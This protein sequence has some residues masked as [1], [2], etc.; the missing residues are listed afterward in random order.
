MK[1]T[2]T[3]ILSL[4]I[5][6]FSFGQLDLDYQ[7]PHEEILT[8]ADAKMPPVMSI[9]DDG[10]KAILIYRDQYKSIVELAEKEMRLAGLRINPVTNISSRTTFY[11]KIALF[12]PK[13]KEQIEV[14]G[15]PE[16]PRLSNLSWSPKQ[17]YIT[18]L[19]TTLT[20]NELWVID[21]KKKK[22]I[23]LTEGKINA[24]M[25]SAYTWLPNESGLIVKFLPQEKKELIDV[26][27]KVPTGP[28]VSVNEAG[29]EA[30]NRTYQDLLQNKDDEYNFEVLATS[31][32][33]YVNLKGKVKN[34]MDQ[35]MFRSVS[36]SPDG[37]YVLLS[38]VKKPFS[39]IVTYGRFPTD[40]M[41]V[42]QDA[43]L[44]KTIE[45]VPLTEEL[46]KGFM[47]T[48][49]GKRSFS[50]RADHPAT[51][52]W[53]EALDEGNPDNEVEFRDEVFQL[54]A[55]FNGSEESITKTQLRYSSIE[56]SNADVALLNEYWWNTRTVKQSFIYPDHSTKENIVF[57]ER[58]Y[59]DRYAEPGDFVTAKNELNKSV[60]QV[61]NKDKVL[62]E[63]PGYSP[64][65]KF[66]FVDEYSISTTKKNRLYESED[67]DFQESIIRVMDPE[68]G[69]LLVRLESSNQ[70][71]NYFIRNF[72]TGKLDQI[73][74]FEN[75]FKAIE[76]VSKE[77]IKYERGD[78]LELSATLYLPTDFKEGKKYP[79]IMWAYPREYKDKNSASQV[80]SSNKDFTYPYYGSPIYWVNRGYVVL[81]DAAFPIFAEGDEEP[82]DFFVEQLV[83]NAKAAINA[84]DEMGYI[85][86][87]RVAVGGHSY[88][89]F[90]TANLLSH[91]DLFAAGIARSGAY[92]RTLTPFGFQS[93]ERNYWEAPEVYNTMSPFMNAHKMKTPLLLIHGEDDNNSG[94]YPMQSERYFNALKGLGAPVR[95]VM[96][97]KESHGYAAR[98]SIM[99][100]LWEQDQWLEEHLKNKD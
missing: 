48:R 65:G 3:L 95:L 16:N 44:V 73:S 6:T 23:K 39:Y 36:F 59:Q 100:M 29:T 10:T 30:Q 70:F 47:A 64:E 26:A 72:K 71:P 43:N 13:K 25:G 27:Q 12:D 50:W 61:I 90:M 14:K 62:L 67:N 63:G 22:A 9:N 11:N 99:H 57:S 86:P 85:D 53:A 18:F 20:G 46:P 93:E 32:L 88:G 87:E 7:E 98:E 28:T 54:K 55:P 97:P 8:L 74:S 31:E 41:L 34:W 84:V 38:K 77:V 52:I 4:M 69:D 83:G 24:N 49:L 42:D 82:N 89:A 56:W 21:Y 5:T 81:D 66:P 1:K 2:A 75:P 35:A 92:N 91:S 60:I 51:I 58:N 76:N 17:N 68:K 78:G 94:T 33:K 45:E 40:Y 96:L 19:N 80:T 15:M 37:N 79:M